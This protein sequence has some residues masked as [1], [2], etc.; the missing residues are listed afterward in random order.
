MA[1]I[2]VRQLK[3][4]T[5]EILRRVEDGEEIVVTRRGKPCAK[6][7]PAP[8]AVPPESGQ[9]RTLRGMFRGWPDLT[10]EDFQEAK[11]IWHPISDPKLPDE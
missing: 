8:V 5:S 2:G 4:Q 11:K 6:L 1:T 7:I 10:W 3:S 9:H